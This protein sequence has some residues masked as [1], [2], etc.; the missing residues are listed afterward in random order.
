M[1]DIAA[2]MLELGE[3]HEPIRKRSTKKDIEEFIKWSYETFG[4]DLTKVSSQLISVRYY[5]ETGK[6]VSPSTIRKYRTHGV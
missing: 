6:N 3:S 5:H 1:T 2:K 4:D